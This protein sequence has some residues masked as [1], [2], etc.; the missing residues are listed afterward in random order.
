M[1]NP[2]VLWIRAHSRAAIVQAIHSHDQ[3]RLGWVWILGRQLMPR[4]GSAPGCGL[5]LGLRF[6]AGG[7]RSSRYGLAATPRSVSPFGKPFPRFGFRKASID[8]A[9]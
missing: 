9:A 6:V 1:L 5:V 7:T 4:L 2:F 8:R 3:N